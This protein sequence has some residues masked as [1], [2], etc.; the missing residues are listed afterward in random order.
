LWKTY[1]T[2]ASETGLFFTLPELVPAGI[3]KRF[4]LTCSGR[5]GIII[6]GKW[7]ER[8]HFLKQPIRG[9]G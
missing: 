3:A 5:D 6:F 4:A 8:G 2:Q 9:F 7:Y 1:K